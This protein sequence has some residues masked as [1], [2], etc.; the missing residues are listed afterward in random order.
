MTRRRISSASNI[1]LQK[2]RKTTNSITNN[3]AKIIISNT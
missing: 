1:I 2:T 3:T